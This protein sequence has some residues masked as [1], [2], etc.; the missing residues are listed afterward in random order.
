VTEEHLSSPFPE[1]PLAA[2]L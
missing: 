2:Q 1:V